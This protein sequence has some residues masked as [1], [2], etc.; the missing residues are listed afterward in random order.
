LCAAVLLIVAVLLLLQSASAVL[1]LPVFLAAGVVVLWAGPKSTEDRR[2]LWVSL[3]VSAF[4]IGSMLG[5]VA[6]LVQVVDDRGMYGDPYVAAGRYSGGSQELYYG[7]DPVENVYAFDSEGEPLT[8]VYLYDEDG[9]PLT[10]PRFGCEE[11]TGSEM[12]LGE[13]NRFP[14]P[15]IEY[16]AYDDQGNYNGYNA[17]RAACRETT[18]VP[19]SAAIPNEVV[20]PPPPPK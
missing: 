17:Y 9:R 13:D 19:F 6:Q 15:H 11:S 1:A 10:L 4:V 3:P 16:G 7:N 2:L 20:P 8:G 12:R 18:A 14:R 5:L